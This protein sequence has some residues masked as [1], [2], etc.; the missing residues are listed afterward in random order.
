MQTRGA[1]TTIS[2]TMRTKRSSIH[3]LRGQAGE[4]G[5]KPVTGSHSPGIP[6]SNGLVRAIRGQ[7]G[8]NPGARSLPSQRAHF[9]PLYPYN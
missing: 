3:C 5:V 1:C 9:I 6:T 8:K 7:T 4:E 2:T